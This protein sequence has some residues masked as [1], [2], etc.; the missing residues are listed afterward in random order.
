MCKCVSMH[1]LYNGTMLALTHS[2]PNNA[3]G[4]HN[5]SRSSTTGTQSITCTVVAPPCWSHLI[6]EKARFWKAYLR[7]QSRRSKHITTCLSTYLMMF[8]ACV[9]NSSGCRHRAQPAAECAAT[10]GSACQ[11]WNSIA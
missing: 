6:L 5:S 2:D 1:N 9:R 10:A 8:Q 7:Q 3:K 11:A 4:P